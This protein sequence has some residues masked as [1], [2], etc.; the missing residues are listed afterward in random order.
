MLGCL[1]GNVG[2]PWDFLILGSGVQAPHWVE[3]LLKNK[4]AN[5]LKKK[6]DAD[7][8]IL[9]TCA[10]PFFGNTVFAEDQLKQISLGWVL[11]Q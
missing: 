2:R 3:R 10:I 7:V 9:S 4:P 6:K 1:A 5:K 11:V 8:L